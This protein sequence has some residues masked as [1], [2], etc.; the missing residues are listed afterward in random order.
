[1]TVTAFA[2]LLLIPIVFF[3]F[4]PDSVSEIDNR[5]LAED[6]FTAEGDFRRIL[7]TISMTASASEA[8]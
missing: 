7:K 8:A 5:K 6:P 2:V 3:N 4:T 1:M